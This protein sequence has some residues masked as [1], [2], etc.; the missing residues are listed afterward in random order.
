MV[1]HENVSEDRGFL[2]AAY[3]A[4]YDDRHA[5]LELCARGDQSDVMHGVAS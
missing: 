1:E 4:G 2:L 5:L 3:A